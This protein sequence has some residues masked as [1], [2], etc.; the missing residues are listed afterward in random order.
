M[1]KAW[2]WVLIAAALFVTWFVLV[3]PHALP[4][5]LHPA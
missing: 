2:V 5:F 4:L 3:A 1:K